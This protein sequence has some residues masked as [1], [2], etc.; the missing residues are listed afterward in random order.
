MQFITLMSY[1]MVLMK[2][3]AVYVIH[4]GTDVAYWKNPADLDAHSNC[5]SRVKYSRKA[6]QWVGLG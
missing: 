2:F 1:V 4:H 5:N 3:Y 6:G